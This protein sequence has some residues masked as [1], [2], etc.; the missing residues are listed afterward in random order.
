MWYNLQAPKRLFLVDVNLQ[1]LGIEL[2]KNEVW[3]QEWFSVV[4]SFIESFE[5]Q[6]ELVQLLGITQLHVE[7]PEKTQCFSKSFFRLTEDDRFEEISTNLSITRDE[8]YE[9]LL[10]QTGETVEAKIR[11]KFS[12]DGIKYLFDF[13]ENSPCAIMQIEAA[14]DDFSENWKS[15]FERLNSV[16]IVDVSELSLEE[17]S[18]Q[19]HSD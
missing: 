15:S 14:L 13:L 6:K 10:M 7:N 16:N 1:E 12:L 8:Y 2:E 18:Y 3:D 5:E 4:E 19:L 17:L 9:R 11:L